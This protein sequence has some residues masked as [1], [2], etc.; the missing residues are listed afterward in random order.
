M[1]PLGLNRR[2]DDYR[3]WEAWDQVAGPQI[4]RNSRPLKLDSRRLVVAVR[5]AAWMQELTLLK[6]ELVA[7]LNQWMGRE[8]IDDLLLVVGNVE[9]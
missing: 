5:S 4:A 1:A 3:I 7:K 9:E 2:L 6:G 8:V